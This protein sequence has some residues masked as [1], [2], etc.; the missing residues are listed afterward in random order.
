MVA[1]GMSRNTFS[2]PEV[3]G[4]FPLR[5]SN[6]QTEKAYQN[7][8]WRWAAYGLRDGH[9]EHGEDYGSE[10]LSAGAG[11]MLQLLR[12]MLVYEP[13][14]NN[15]KP[16]GQL[17]LAN[18]IPRSWL[19]DGKHLEVDEAPTYF[20][21]VSYSVTSHLKQGYIDA[22]IN[23]PQ[24]TVTNQIVLHLPNPNGAEIRQVKLNGQTWKDF[25]H[26]TISLPGNKGRLSVIAYY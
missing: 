26:D 11:V 13:K 20:G 18:L 10:P 25:H 3:T 23:P 5:V 15:G 1:N 12:R 21:K 8:L 9:P 2:S 24:R 22:T 17:A 6:L 14:D 16:T 19:K 4:V 7:N